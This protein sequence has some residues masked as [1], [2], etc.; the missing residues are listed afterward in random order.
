[1]QNMP[2][3]KSQK[4]DEK[5][6]RKSHYYDNLITKDSDEE[7]DANDTTTN[8]SLSMLPGEED[9]SMCRNDEETV[10]QAVYAQD[11]CKEPGGSWGVHIYNINVKPPDL[12]EQ[13]VGCRLT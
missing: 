1:M 7:E 4:E 9:L 13:E 5:N 2:K 12:Q 3:K 11:F 8:L 6:K 10:L